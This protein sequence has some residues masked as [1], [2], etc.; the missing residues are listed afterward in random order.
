MKENFKIWKPN[1]TIREA[2]RGVGLSFL[3][4]FWMGMV[5]LNFGLL[6]LG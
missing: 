4:L 1:E 3:F 6:F 2:E 5:G